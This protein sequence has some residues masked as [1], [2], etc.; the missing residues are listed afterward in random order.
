MSRIK[1]FYH[2]EICNGLLE[3]VDDTDFFFAKHQK[4]LN[5]NGNNLSNCCSA[6]MTVD[7]TKE[8][9]TF[10]DLARCPLCKEHA[11]TKCADCI[12]PC[13]KYKSIFS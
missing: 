4:E 11:A 9:A 8:G 12:T 6:D 10:F 2:E 5:C 3:E 1:E 7:A 13:S